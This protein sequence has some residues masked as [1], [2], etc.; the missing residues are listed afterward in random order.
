MAGPAGG[1]AILGAGRSPAPDP[2][3]TKPLPSGSSAVRAFG[4]PGA[5][6]SV[7]SSVF[8]FFFSSLTLG[9]RARAPVLRAGLGRLRRGSGTRGPGRA[10]TRFSPPSASRHGFLPVLSDRVGLASPFPAPLRFPAPW[11]AVR[12]AR[13]SPTSL[14]RERRRSCPMFA[15]SSP[16][17]ALRAVNKQ[18]FSSRVSAV[19]ISSPRDKMAVNS[20]G[21]RVGVYVRSRPAC[22]T[23]HGRVWNRRTEEAGFPGPASRSP[24]NARAVDLSLGEAKLDVFETRPHRWT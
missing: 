6:S 8:I 20:C 16:R 15:A 10:R 17:A 13:A 19:F 2:P 23:S 7:F 4:I 12:T 21:A 14:A 3:Q 24:G 11:R 22:D 1:G 9:V 5:R 18:H